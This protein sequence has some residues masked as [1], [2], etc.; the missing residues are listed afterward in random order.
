METRYLG[1]LEVLFLSAGKRTFIASEKTN[2]D[3]SIENR[4]NQVK[5]R[6]RDACRRA[7]RDPDEVHLLVVSKTHGPE[8]IREAA[9][10]GLTV[11]GENRVQEAKQKIPDCPG[12]LSWHMVGHLQTNKARYASRLF[13]MIHSVDSLKLLTAI[14][15]ACGTNGVV[16][17]VCL[18][19]NVSGESTK[20]GLAPE[21]VPE[22][23]SA[24]NGLMHV[25]VVGLMTIPPISEDHE[26][27]RPYFKKLREFRDKWRD[28]TGFMLSELSMGMSHDFEIAIE[29]GATW[30]RLG[31]MILGK[32]G[33]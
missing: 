2:M 25:D 27:A 28:Q 9:D 24:A 21:S 29:E 18:E 33:M 26:E 31:T 30:I 11:F 23:L 14:N 15:T 4:L 8:K 10:C 22:V 6:I 7:G 12:H 1:G 32:R 3:E 13:Q 5:T 19:V 16:M 20:F 17:P